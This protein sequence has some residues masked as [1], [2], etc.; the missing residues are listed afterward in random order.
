MTSEIEVLEASV[1]PATTKEE[2]SALIA[3]AKNGE[4]VERLTIV[5]TQSQ[6]TLTLDDGALFSHVTVVGSDLVLVQPDGAIIVLVGANRDGLTIFAENF[7][8]LSSKL[9]ELADINSDWE[10][11]EGIQAVDLLGA[12]KVTQVSKPGSGEPDAT[13]VLDP[14]I[15][16]P[17]NPL[18]PPTEYVFQERDDLWAAGDNGTG[19]SGLLVVQTSPFI[20]RETDATVTVNFAD[21]FSITAPNVGNDLTLF[22]AT[23][24]VTGIP[25]GSTVNYGT[26]TDAGNGTLTLNFT[27]SE[28]QYENL[29]LVFPTDFSTVSRLDFAPGPL[30]GTLKIESVF[31]EVSEVPFDITVLYEGDVTM[32]GPGVINTV[33]TDAEVDWKPSDALIP[34]ATDIDGSESITNVAFAMPGLPANTL[35]SLDNGAT[36]QALPATYGFTGTLAEYMDIVVRLPTDF[37]TENPNMNL[38]GVVIATTNEGGVSTRSFALNVD[39][40]LD[41]TLT[42]PA[43]LNGVEDGN[44]T[45]GSGVTIDLGIDV[46]ATDLDGSEDN[47]TVRIEFTGVPSG[48]VFSTGFYGSNNGVWH[49]TMAQA[50]SLTLTFPGDFSGSISSIIYANSPEGSLQT[51]QAIVIAPTGDIDFDITPITTMETDAPV[52][53]RPA[54]YWKVSISDNDPGVPPETLDTVTLTLND[55]PPGMV[56][57]GVPASTISYNDATGGTLVFSGTGLQYKALRLVFPKDYSTESPLTG[58]SGDLEGVLT[59]TSTED[60]TGQSVAVNIR[61]TPE[62]D[63]TIDD[64]LP[65][66]IPDETDSVTPVSPSSLFAPMATDIDGSESIEELILIVA[67][68]P[69]NVTSGSDINLNAPGATAAFSKA[70]DGSVTMTLTLTNAGGTDVVTAFNAIGFELAADF[71]TANRSDLA[72]NQTQ[73]PLTFTL[74]VTTDEDAIPLIDTSVDG[75][76]TSVRVVDIGFE[77]DIDLAAPAKVT[78]LEDNNNTTAGVT[79]DLEIVASIGDI[80]DSETEDPNDPLFAPTVTVTFT[81]LPAGAAPVG[82]GAL[83]GNVWSGSIAELNNLQLFLPENYSGNLI[84]DIRVETREGVEAT[85]QIIE[86]KPVPDDNVTVDIVATETDAELPLRFGD[87]SVIDD[88]DPDEVITFVSFE[89]T[90]VPAGFYATVGG[91]NVGTIVGGTFTWVPP[92]LTDLNNLTMVFPKDYSTESPVGQPQPE[93]AIELDVTESGVTTRETVTSPITIYVEGDVDVPDAVAVLSET[94]AALTLKPADY[95]DPIATDIDGSESVTNVTAYFSGMP[96]GAEYSVAG[97]PYQPASGNFSFTGTLAE[98]EALVLRFPADFSTENPATT[99]SAQITA[100]TDEGGIDSGILEIRISAE[101]DVEVTG[102]GLIDITENDAPGDT[103]EDTT[104]HAPLEFKLVDAVQGN[105]SDADGS[106]SIAQVDVTITGLPAGALYSLNGGTSFAAFAAGGLPPLTLAEYNNLV[107]QLPDDFS[108]ATPIAGS[109]TFTTDEAILNG[110]IDVDATDGIET[111]DFTVNIAS[112]ADVDIDVAD[113]TRIEDFGLPIPLNID[114]TVTD[115]DGSESI[116]DIVVTFDGLPTNGPT[117]LSDGTAT[118]ISVSGPVATLN[119]SLSQL[120]ALSITS[121]P[122][123]FSGII[124]VNVTVVTDEGNTAGT[125]TDFKVNIT[126]VAEPEITLSVDTSPSSVTSPAQDQFVVKEDTTFG[127]VINANT[128]DQDGSEQLTTIVIENVPTGWIPAGT[129]DLTLFSGPDVA[130][131]DSAQMAGTTLTINLVPGTTAFDATV[132]V[133]PLENDDRDVATIV[134]ADLVGTVTSEDSAAGLPTDTATAVDAIDVDVDAVVDGASVSTT[135]VVADENKT[136]P[137]KLNLGISNLALVDNDGSETISELDLTFTFETASTNFDPSDPAQFSLTVP[138]VHQGNITIVETGSTANSV[139]YKFTPTFGASNTQFMDALEAIE[140]GYPQHYSGITTIDGEGYWNET[141]TND[142]EIDTSDNFS[143]LQT[144]QFTQTINPLSEVLFSTSVFVLSSAEVATG[145]PTAIEAVNRKGGTFTVTDILTLLESTDDGSGPGQV[146]VFVSLEGSTPDLDG[147]EQLDKIVIENVP[148]DWIAQY[149]SGGNIDQAAF[150]DPSGTGPIPASEYAK[151]SSATYNSGTGKVEITFAAGVTTFEA[152]IQLTPTLYED[153]DIDRSDTDDFTSAGS[154][155]GADLNVSLKTIDTNTATNASRKAAAI[156][157]VDTDPVNNFATINNLPNGNE[158]V[159]D[160]AGG[161]WG[162]SLLPH[163][164]DMDGSEQITAIVLRGVPE[165]VTVYVTDINNPTGPKVPALITEVGVPT[166]FNSWSLEG[167]AALGIY[168]WEN[169]EFHG[170][171][172]HWAGD[173][174]LALQVVST[175]DDGGTRVTNIGVPIYID[176]VADGGDPSETA[177]TQE[178]TAVQ[179]SIDGNIIDNLTNS[180]GSPEAILGVVKL[181]NVQADSFGRHPRFFDGDPAAGG[182]E[183]FLSGGQVILTPA[184]AQN[185]W[186]LPGQDSNEDVVFDVSVEYYETIDLTEFTAATGTVTISVQGIADPVILT[187]QQEDPSQV[188]GGIQQSDV[189]SD[190]RPGTEYDNVYGYAGN[191]DQPFLLDMRLTDL[192]LENGLNYSGA[193]F[194]AATP[195]QGTMTE[196]TNAGNFDGSETLYYVITGVDPS[197]SFSGGFLSNTP[198][199]GGLDSYIVSASELAALEFVPTSVSEVTYYDLKIHAIVLEDDQDTSGLPNTS[200]EDNLNYLN[201]LP[202]GSVTT[203]DFAIVVL[204]QSGG[205]NPCDPDKMIGLPTLSLVGSGDEDTEIAFQLQLNPDGTYTSIS[206]LTNLPNGVNGNFTLEIDLPPGAMIS[207]NP[208]GAVLLDPSTGGYVVDVAQLGIDPSDPTLTAGSILFTPPPHQ[209]SP[210]NPF[211]PGETFGPDDPYDNLNSLDYSMTLENFSCNMQT[212]SGPQSFPI[213]IHPVVDGPE[214]NFTGA[215]KFDEDTDYA[216]GLDVTGP[217]GGERLVGNVEITISGG[218]S[219]GVVLKDS[220]GAVLLPNPSGTYSVPKDDVAGLTLR[221]TEHYSGTLT[222]T[223]SATSEDINGDQKTVDA[224]KT[225]EITAVADTPEI[226]FDD[227][228]IDPETGQPYVD[229]SGGQAVVTIIEDNAFLLS[230][231]VTA[232]TPDQDGSETIS[233]VLSGVPDYLKVSGPSG[234]GFID[235]GDGSYTISRSAFSS[236][237]LQLKDEHARTPDPLDPS[238]PASIPLTLE[239]STIELSNSDTAST[240]VD[241]SVVVLPDADIPT[242]TASIDPTT[243]TE[244]QPQPYTLTLEATTPDPH[245]TIYFEITDPG[246]GQIFLG[247][248]ALTSSLGVYTIPGQL[249]GGTFVPTD[250]VTFVPGQDFG[251]NVALEVV[252]V[253]VD[254]SGSYTDE[255]RSTP[256]DLDLTVTPAPDLNLTVLTPDVVLQETDAPVDYTPAADFDISVT[257]TDGSEVVDTVTYTINGVPSGTT[258]SVSGGTPVPVSGTLVFTGSLAEFNGLSIQFPTDFATNGTDLTGSIQVTTNEGGNESGNFNI[259]VAGELDL[260]ATN[261]TPIALAESGSDV[262]VEFEIIATVTDTQATPSETLEEVVITFNAPIPAAASVSIGTFDA[263]RT[264]LTITR[265]TMD[266]ALFTAAVAALTLTFP[267][268]VAMPING[269]ITVTTNHGSAPALPYVVELNQ[270]PVVSAPLDFDS[271]TTTL[272]L[273]FTD[274]LANATDPEGNGMTIVSASTNDPDVTVTLLANSVQITVPNGYIGTPVL[275]YTIQDDGTPNA[276][277]E[278]T[279]NLDFNTMQMTV[280]GVAPGGQQLMSDVIGGTGSNDTALATEFDDAVIYSATRTYADVEA[281]SMLGGD[282][283]VDLS[284]AT[285]GFEVY[286]GGGDDV[287]IGSNQS[288]ILSGGTGS[289]TLTGGGGSDIFELTD[290]QIA[291]VITDYVSPTAS[292]TESDQ[293]D[294][295]ALVKLSGSEIPTDRISYN[296]GSGDL[297]VDGVSVAA[298]GAAAGF[299]DQVEVIFLDAQGAQQ[300]AVL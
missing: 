65:D 121:F 166:G 11:I 163:I 64:S 147:S 73:L 239:V 59:A 202:G 284:A 156:F 292:A 51:N 145:S 131:I 120:Q 289:D 220:S 266:V 105:A 136:G 217:D 100:L 75:Q 26:L 162:V 114:A 250:T 181:E 87:Y 6:S 159:I 185:L 85:Q 79:V 54:E 211:A 194:E 210:V 38:T 281:F 151:I 293:I 110:E 3:A 67:G 263:S 44:G 227:T 256:A 247:P 153:Y 68:L 299:S 154:F 277:T 196:I 209:S 172:K 46:V 203:E 258:Y 126:P 252:A 89:M 62:G 287:L 270:A 8:I 108:T 35:I 133:A 206:D 40:E 93:I 148:E 188:T 96:A 128:P 47:T 208:P 24:N 249:S 236:V 32:D 95:I 15:G 286:G 231:V 283:F 221:P 276:S 58:A 146:E 137:L 142:V 113:L 28:S 80:D 41:L 241:F 245:E 260:D 262:V 157:D 53:V 63:V 200:V 111:K 82:G 49:G 228:I 14:L 204:P 269:D 234:S 205:G 39:Y 274:L 176:P 178:D 164:P 288:D 9:A 189:D 214:I 177:N 134:G 132:Q 109:V 45:D 56:F 182:T 141:T 101:G 60:P 112:E 97:G 275:T 229:N 140:V 94:D 150:F 144:F 118:P 42:A 251:G 291:D 215:N 70:A 294:L 66:T 201:S 43:V 102:P 193:M 31:N 192:A 165:V 191:D 88:P 180:P 271:I 273:T 243:G 116:T 52:V 99:L 175:E 244:D 169:L 74:K 127:L 122:E 90:N 255:E 12:N 7:S 238:I 86:I 21:H 84:A 253:T 25:V 50:N 290:L 161:I 69:G 139:S 34:R 22:T 138:A 235:N 57:N 240:T 149:V 81:G 55:L 183:I 4:T 279:A 246:N 13:S 195:L 259:E 233:I 295:T 76:A 92:N 2:M 179:I 282:D 23:L 16:L 222:I 30:M 237:T 77:E 78:A 168:Q 219:A 254:S 218:G 160:D 143:T 72:G 199:A 174:V 19:A 230:D 18:L 123:H 297:Q 186:V 223:V 268:A 1:T 20:L 91:A 115:I 216:L 300:T 71:S 5:E 285:T 224:S 298:V 261:T 232:D 190:F 29:T 197:T 225:I 257:D 267:V 107:F 242:L 248:N 170:I 167:N 61:I 119:L 36:F 37:S 124:D 135:D 130:S 184:Q 226:K 173:F 187:A 10:S 27:G 296:S 264:T 212:D 48:T 213:V 117:I 272:D 83:T 278:A 17:I 152:S 125:S 104:S 129:V 265:G 98:Y 198:S 280:D 155:F 207:S 33:E 103:D 106:E 171:P 158:Q